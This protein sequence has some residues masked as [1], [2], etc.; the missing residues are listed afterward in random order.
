MD[1]RI[2]RVAMTFETIDDT[3]LPEKK[4]HTFNNRVFKIPGVV[5]IEWYYCPAVEIE[6]K[7]KKHLNSV[8]R[9]IDK[10]IADLKIG[11]V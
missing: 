5:A 6:P 10:T 4:V 8:I 1:P 11:A 7:N 3:K 2:Y 9:R